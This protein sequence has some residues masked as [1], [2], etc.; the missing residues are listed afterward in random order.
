M[1]QYHTASMTNGNLCTYTCY[2]DMSVQ[3]VRKFPFVI[4][5]LPSMD[6]GE[7]FSRI[8]DRGDQA[9]TEKGKKFTET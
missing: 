3:H 5:F 7:L 1:S 2:V 9:F 8:Q 6:G 4:L